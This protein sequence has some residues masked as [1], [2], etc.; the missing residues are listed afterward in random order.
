[1]K[2]I[3]IFGGSF[4]PI[5]TAHLILAEHARE[6]AG[7]ER[8]L[9]LPAK[10]PPHKPST[11]LASAEDRLRM[12]QLATEGNPAFEASALELERSGPSYTLLTV[13]QLREQAGPNVCLH[14]IVGADSIADMPNWWRAREL[15]EQV[16]LI[17]L[18]RPH[19]DLETV[20]LL[21]E[22]FGPEAA[23]RLR[24]S[25]I[26]APLIELSATEVRRRVREGRSVRYLV[27]A[28]VRDY[29]LRHGLY[30]DA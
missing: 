20:G 8:V 10:Q 4:N 5:H 22:A 29:I 15:V 6:E 14:L 30:R 28:A 19:V 24:S 3:G 12:V 13:R 27:P 1:M 2:R 11:P 23:R 26:R 25:L 9:F 21:D 7:L 16:E 17:G 18:P